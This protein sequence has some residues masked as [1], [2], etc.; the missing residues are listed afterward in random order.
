MRVDILML[1]WEYAPDVV[2][3]LGRHV[4]S[5]SRALARLG[6][7]VTV[8]APGVAVPDAGA[9]DG[10]EVVRVQDVAPPALDFP[11]RVAQRNA[12]L[13]QGVLS[14]AASGRKFDLVHA[15]DWLTAYA[16]RAAK[17]GLG[18]PLVATIHATEHGRNGG[19]FTDLQRHISDVEWWLTYEAWLV[20]CCSRAMQRELR[21]VF[22][23]PD[24][25]V[26]VVPNGVD[27]P[28]EERDGGLSGE[29]PDHPVVF[30]VGRLVY[31]KGVDLLIA[32]FR[33][34]L[35]E[36]PAAELLIAG[37]GPEE[38]RLRELAHAL[39]I[40]AHVRF[41]GYIPDG[42]RN[43]LYRLADAAVFPSRYEPFGIV[44][45]EAMSYG[46]PV[47][48]ACTGGLA[49]VIEHGRTGIL[50]EPGNAEALAGELSA[51]LK[52]DK[53]RKAL[54]G[55]ARRHVTAAYGWDRVAEATVDVYR[56]VVKAAA[57]A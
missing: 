32:A 51:L 44:A 18:I 35:R 54:G 14:A 50:F 46:A 56:E 45:L 4:T 31:E 52:S 7:R 8:V 37:K 23:V 27:P 3:G 39:G 21:D 43:R 12:G 2:G 42:E 11:E 53:A 38:P 20:I 15:H 41:L 30:F 17:H 34:V 29:R 48:A 28:G 25:K 9:E 16:A 13:L 33:E 49:E 1:S 24:D 6:H 57:R 19:L 55:A 36:H 10:I 26:R 47:V 22:Q 5:L 40:E